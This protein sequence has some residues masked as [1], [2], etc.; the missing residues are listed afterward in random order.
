MPIRR[1]HDAPTNIG[2]GQNPR[3]GA[4][5]TAPPGLDG[6][7]ASVK[8]KPDMPGEFADSVSGGSQ[9][10]SEINA[11]ELEFMPRLRRRAHAGA[12]PG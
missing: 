6:Q 10:L 11:G 9:G 2:A 12:P 7:T 8:T 5:A 3:A 4:V 1:T